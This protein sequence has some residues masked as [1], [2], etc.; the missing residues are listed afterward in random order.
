MKPMKALKPVQALNRLV[1]IAS[2]YAVSQTFFTACRLGLFEQLSKGPATAEDLSQ[3]LSIHPNGCRRLLVALAHLGLVEREDGL[4]QNS[5]LGNFCTSKSPV[6][7]EPISMMGEPFYRMFE[8]LPDALRE[9][10]PRWQQALGTAANE[11][12]AALYEDPARLRRFAQMMNAFS[13]PQGQEIAEHFDFTPYQCVMDV[14]GGPGGIAIQIGLRYPHLRGIVMD[15]APVCE[16]AKEHIQSSGLADRFT[17]AA[18][19]LFTGP[20]P[21]GAD[22]MVL[23]HILHDWSDESCHK[24]LR[25]CIEVLPSPGVL[26]VSESVLNDDFSGTTH[27]LMKDLTMLVACESGARERSKAEYRSLLEEAGFRDVEVIRLEAP[28]DL[29]V[30]RKP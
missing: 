21:R 17:T 1:E 28:R 6:P 29:I 12:F 11:V 13:I 30:A 3:R 2:G 9:F 26:L 16:V 8:Y 5:E 4:Y 20:Y 19:D 14:A 15:M 25:N 23:G 10:S 22:V 7:L 24:I 18:A 27:A